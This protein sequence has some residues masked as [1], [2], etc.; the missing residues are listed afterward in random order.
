MC[1]FSMS[2]AETRNPGVNTEHFSQLQIT[3]EDLEGS[4]TCSIFLLHPTVVRFQIFAPAFCIHS[5]D[6]SF[7]FRLR[8]SLV[9]KIV[10]PDLE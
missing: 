2:N 4:Q 5:T 8:Y 9:K 10:V 3:V 7:F 1:S 6:F